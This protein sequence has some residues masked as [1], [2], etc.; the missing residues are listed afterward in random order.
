V[1]KQR[2]GK[3]EREKIEKLLRGYRSPGKS[4]RIGT[5]S[6]TTLSQFSH[7][8]LLFFASHYLPF[9][10]FFPGC[11]MQKISTKKKEREIENEA[12]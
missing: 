12:S 5:I 8:L 10:V 9:I 4:Y 3:R 7:S 11:G 1:I 6:S 2:D